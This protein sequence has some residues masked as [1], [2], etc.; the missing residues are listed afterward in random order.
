M[1]PK[2]LRRALEAL[3]TGPEGYDQA[4]QQAM[5][6]VEGQ[7]LKCKVLAKRVLSWIVCVRQPLTTLEL[8]HALAVEIGESEFDLEN[9]P[10][11]EDLVSICAGLVTVDLES[12]IICLLHYTTQEYFKRSQQ[13]WFPNAQRDIAEV[14]VAYLS[15]DRFGSE[16]YVTTEDLEPILQEYPLYDYVARNWGFHA[17]EGHMQIEKIG[18][19]FLLSDFKVSNSVQAA[20]DVIDD[21]PTSLSGAHL[22]AYFEL[23]DN[24]I[25][26]IEH[27]LRADC[28]DSRR[29]TPLSWA[30][31]HGRL[32]VAELLLRRD[33]V[34]P[35]FRNAIE[36]TPLW[37]A[38]INR[39]VG[40]VERLLQTQRVDPESRW[41][42][43]RMPLIA[44]AQQG[45]E[46][47]FKLLLQ[48]EGVDPNSRDYSGYTALLSTAGHGHTDLA[49]L[50]LQRGADRDV[51]IDERRSGPA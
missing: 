40:V 19:D 5:E 4:Y 13:N 12:D 31:E 20:S 8:R 50:L 21:P 30:A 37:R 25:C 47:I 38:I 45:N 35:N 24:L 3:P 17:R 28:I 39:H 51:R 10:E 36:Q 29:N 11:T 15:F 23:C 1:S 22:S 9:L 18:L 46:A 32:A 6:R 27:G 26:L 33:D 44:V 43:G 49:K 48:R 7:V 42:F 41:S 34:D 14:C 2:T 16:R